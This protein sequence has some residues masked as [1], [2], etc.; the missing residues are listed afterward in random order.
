MAQTLEGIGGLLEA[1]AGAEFSFCP[2]RQWNLDATVYLFPNFTA[3]G[4]VRTDWKTT[5]RVRLIPGRKL[6]WD[7]SGTAS[8]GD[9]PP[10]LAPGND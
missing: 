4:R 7:I 6:W 10:A 2:F 8:L 9:K 3:A 5:F 1:C